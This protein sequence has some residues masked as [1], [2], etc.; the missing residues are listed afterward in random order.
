M[1]REALPSR[2]RSTNVTFRYRNMPV[3]MQ[4]G[5]YDDGRLGEIFL[6][7]RMFGSEIDVIMH[8]VALAVSIAL[9]HVATMDELARSA[10]RAEG[11]KPDGIISVIAD[12]VNMSLKT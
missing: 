4:M 3:E 2:R 10:A 5:F 11:G 1:A 6:N 12:T 9:Q 7:T 8:D